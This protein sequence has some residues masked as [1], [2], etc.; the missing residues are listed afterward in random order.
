[1]CKPMPQNL[2]CF[3]FPGAENDCGERQTRVPIKY[4]DTQLLTGLQGLSRALFDAP[5]STP[6]L[7]SASSSAPCTH[8]PSAHPL[9]PTLPPPSSGSSAS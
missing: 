8:T 2:F 4:S 1:M 7:D 9:P 6:T 5:A 3:R